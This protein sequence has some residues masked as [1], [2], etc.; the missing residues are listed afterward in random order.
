LP[1]TG[2]TV[3]GPGVRIVTLCG[4]FGRIGHL[5]LGFRCGVQRVE[6]FGAATEELLG[7][8]GVAGGEVRPALGVS[9]SDDVGHQ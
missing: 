8:L 2:S 3:G 9:E 6:V 1:V 4:R 7:S 5:R